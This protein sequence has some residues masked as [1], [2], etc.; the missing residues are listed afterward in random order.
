MNPLSRRR[1]NHLGALAAG[2]AALG[3]PALVRAVAALPRL[4]VRGLMAIPDHAPDFE[5]QLALH[6][7]TRQL[8]DQIFA[9]Q[10][11]GLEEFDTL[12]L[13]MTADLEAAIAAGSTMVRVGT[14]VFGGRSYP[15]A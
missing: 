14:G 7:R 15:A 4:R 6:T 8:F 1:F 11:P 9:L 3:A 10:A 2:A 5:A 13:G 12:S